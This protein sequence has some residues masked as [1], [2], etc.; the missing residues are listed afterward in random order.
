[1]TGRQVVQRLK[2]KLNII[3]KPAESQLRPI[4]K[5]L[6]ELRP[7]CNL[8]LGELFNIKFHWF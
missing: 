7:C 6:D 4:F 1:M 2:K 5:K 8:I 3:I